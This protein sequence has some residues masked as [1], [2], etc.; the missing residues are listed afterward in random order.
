MCLFFLGL[1]FLRPG[2][3]GSLLAGGLKQASAG[4][5]EAAGTVKP[6]TSPKDGTPAGEAGEAGI[7][8]REEAR[9][10][11]PWSLPPRRKT[12]EDLEMKAALHAAQQAQER[13]A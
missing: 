6:A 8:P 9:D 7:R 4:E 2:W 3:W 10:E 1:L 13:E 11:P 12:Q 5:A